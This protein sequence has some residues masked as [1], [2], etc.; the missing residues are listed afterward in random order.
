MENLLQ[1]HQEFTK[2]GVLISF[3]GSLSNSII[4]EIGNAIKRYLHEENREKGMIS[5]IFSAYIEQTQ[6]INN[7]IS[8]HDIDEAHR[9]S[10]ILI[11]SVNCQYHITSGNSIRKADVLSLK[12]KI[13]HI[14]S[15]DK[16]GLKQYHK[17]QRRKVR[18][19]DAKTAGLGLIDIARRSQGGLVYRFDPLDDEYDFFSL[20]VTI[21]GA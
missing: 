11:S 3:N 13:D 20:Q 16:E 12:Q 10:I 19:P 9:S 1:L 2:T 15:L 5:D 14:N 6:N 21:Q 8:C 18:D 7:Y 17:E 4:E